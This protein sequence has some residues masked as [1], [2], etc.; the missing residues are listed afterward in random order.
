MCGICGVIGFERTIRPKPLPADDG[1]ASAS[2]P[3]RSWAARRSSVALGVRRSVSL[4]FPAVTSPSSTK[5]TTSRCLQRRDLQL[6]TIAWHAGRTRPR[7]SHAFRHRSHRTRLRRMGRRVRWRT[8]RDVAFAVWDARASALPGCGATREFSSRA[9]AGH[10]AALLFDRQRGFS[11][12]LRSSRTDGKWLHCARVAADSLEA[13]LLFGSVAEPSTLV[14]GVFSLPPDIPSHCTRTLPGDL[15]PKRYWDF[16][17]AALQTD[18][19]RPKNFKDAAKQ[20]RS[21]LEETVRD[22]LIAMSLSACSSRA[23]STPPRWW[24][25]PAVARVTC[26]LHGRVSRTAFSESKISRETAKHF[27][28]NHQEVLLL[29]TSLAQLDD[30]VNALDQPTMDGLNTY[31][32]SGQRIWRP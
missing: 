29:P 17:A 10:Q 18:S 31:F 12:C 3:G 26:A 6:Q 22:H 19:A 21:L 15:R 1:G 14:E 2:R 24:R 27:N 23:A 28:T 5:P 4:T 25:S 7:V 20:L 32:V 13:Y 30:A 8:S 9:I 16:S 11:V